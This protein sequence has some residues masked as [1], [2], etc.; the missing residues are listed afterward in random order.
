MSA[1]DDAIRLLNTCGYAVFKK[2]DRHISS[3]STT[4]HEAE[5]EHAKDSLTR[6]FPHIE[7]LEARVTSE[8]DDY[9]YLERCSMKRVTVGFVYYPDTVE[10]KPE[11]RG[12]D[13]VADAQAHSPEGYQGGAVRRDFI[14]GWA[15]A[16]RARY[17]IR[18]EDIGHTIRADRFRI[19]EPG[20]RLPVVDEPLREVRALV[21]NDGPAVRP[22]D[23]LPIPVDFGRRETVSG[24]SDTGEVASIT[25]EQSARAS[26]LGP[27]DWLRNRRYVPL[28]P[29]PTRGTEVQTREI[30][31]YRG[32]AW[33]DP[34]D[35]SRENPEVLLPG[36]Q[37]IRESRR[38]DGFEEKTISREHGIL[39]R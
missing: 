22:E 25:T 17:T 14:Q 4:C 16:D 31:R 7:G 19:A 30:H 6:R 32:G 37:I 5:V 26:G 23:W 2:T 38:G 34:T 10:A 18:N 39:Y 29:I 15:A 21:N 9:G 28:P 24:V 8:R 35:E 20:E 12:I 11:N 3:M 13:V 36:E 33:F 1:I 27:I